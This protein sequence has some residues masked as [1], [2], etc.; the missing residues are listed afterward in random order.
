MI[1]DHGVNE[2][3]DF[4]DYLEETRGTGCELAIAWARGH[5]WEDVDVDAP[6]ELGYYLLLE[7]L[8]VL[9]PHFRAGTILSIGRDPFWSAR[10]WL[11]V[12]GLTDEEYLYLFARAYP[13]YGDRMLGWLEK[14]TAPASRPLPA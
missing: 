1:F 7:Y 10:T 12:P 5:T 6:L 8:D 11:A 2:L 9:G 3:S 13:R 4:A 14:G